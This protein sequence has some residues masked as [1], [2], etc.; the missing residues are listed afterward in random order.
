M[1]SVLCDFVRFCLRIGTFTLQN[2]IMGDDFHSCVLANVNKVDGDKK[3]RGNRGRLSLLLGDMSLSPCL[4]V[5]V[6]PLGKWVCLLPATLFSGSC[7]SR[8]QHA[9][10]RRAVPG[11]GPCP[12]TLPASHRG[13]RHRGG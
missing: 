6:C 11:A 12:R 8:W 5:C 4:Y 13:R 10:V 7:R 1:L 2:V 9:G 3:K